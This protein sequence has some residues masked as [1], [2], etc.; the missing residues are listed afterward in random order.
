[1]T[2]TRV[3]LTTMMATPPRPSISM[4]TGVADLDQAY[5]TLEPLLSRAAAAIDFG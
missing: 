5:L 2:I 4:V 1:M 3:L